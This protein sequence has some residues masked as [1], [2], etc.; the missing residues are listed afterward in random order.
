MIVGDNDNQ[1]KIKIDTKIRN[2][3][4]EILKSR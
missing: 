3:K 4:Y 2:K 1:K